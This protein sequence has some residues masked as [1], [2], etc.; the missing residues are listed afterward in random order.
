MCYICR[1]YKRYRNNAI[2]VVQLNAAKDEVNR[3]WRFYRERYY[4]DLFSKNSSNSK[5]TEKTIN[6]VLGR[7]CNK[8]KIA[9]IVGGMVVNKPQAS[10]LKIIS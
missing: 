2:I 1:R 8:S 9:L 6:Q 3:M 10:K 5:V 4:F 7:K